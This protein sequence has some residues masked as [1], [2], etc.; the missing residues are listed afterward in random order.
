M[1]EGTLG[2]LIPYEVDEQF[3]LHKW[4]FCDTRVQARRRCGGPVH[5][6]VAGAW[7]DDVSIAAED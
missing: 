5:E 3:L 1:F 6:D 2:I 4:C 7:L